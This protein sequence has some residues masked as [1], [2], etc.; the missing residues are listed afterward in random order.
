MKDVAAAA[1]VHQTSVSLALRNH[2]SLPGR[3]RERI[4]RIAREMGYRPDR[5]VSGLAADRREQSTPGNEPTIAYIMDLRG[6]AE[7]ERSP[8]RQLFLR[9]ARERAAELG[10]RVEVFYYAPGYYHSKS[11]DRTLRARNIEG[12]IL[13]AFW[14]RQTD[15]ELTWERFSVIKIE[16]L[17]F[18]LLFD[19][20]QN[21]QFQVT[22]LAMEALQER[23]F[24]RVGMAVGEHDE[25]HTRN[26]FSAGY[27]VGQTHYAPEDRVPILVFEGKDLAKDA[28]VVAEWIRRERVEVVVSNW[29]ELDPV[30]AQAN[31]VLG[32][33]VRMVHLDLGLEDRR[34]AGVRQNHELVGRYAV[35][36]VAGL[37]RI[38]KKGMTPCPTTHLIDGF[39][40]AGEGDD[41][42][43]L[44]AAER[45]PAD[46]VT[47]RRPS[48][49][50]L[51]G[52]E[53]C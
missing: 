22:R 8:P 44:P 37:M 4:Q 23:G 53:G 21:N 14:D 41:P 28:D 32:G 36:Q 13:G 20:V 50:S 25:A 26:L 17:P 3:T 47:I 9:H 24:R 2:P 46:A 52:P 5:I 38:H 51:A 34:H 30:I 6:P 12:L 7:L 49:G 18:N 27:Y 15:L 19:V 43:F 40:E 16:T 45:M 48:R 31:E 10:Y 11:L 42:I 29:P 39:W 33:A 1:G 35:E